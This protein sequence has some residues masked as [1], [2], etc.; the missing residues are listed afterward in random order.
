MLL[1][2]QG[3]TD[4]ARAAVERALSE[5]ADPLPRAA[6]LPAAIRIFLQAGDVE[7]A[8]A[9]ADELARIAADHPT[10]AMRAEADGAHGAVLLASGDPRQALTCLRA[11]WQAWRELDAP[12]EAARVRGCRW[13]R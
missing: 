5:T 2:A 9:A 11:A 8:R 6:L 1:L 10:V 7:A 4:A 12:Y 13:R 3:R